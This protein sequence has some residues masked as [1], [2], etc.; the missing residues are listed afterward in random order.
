MASDGAIIVGAGPYGLSLASYLRKRNIGFQIFG[1]QM[2]SW[3]MHMPVG[4][5]LKSEAFASNLWD[6]D[7]EHTLE[8]FYNSSGR[9]YARKGTPLAV[10]DLLNYSDWF[11][12]RAVPEIADRMLVSL[13]RNGRDFELTFSDGHRIEAERVVLATGHM[14]FSYVPEVL[15]KLPANVAT[16]SSV[17]RDFA[18]FSGRDVTVVGAG[19]SALETAALL[20]EQGVHVRVIARAGEVL[21][22]LP[23]RKSSGVQS[24]MHVEAGLGPGW[25]AWA[26]SELPR[27]FSRLPLEKRR[28]IVKTAFGP[29]GGWW[30]KE[31]VLRKIPLLTAHHI[32]D[33]APQGGKVLLSVQHAG[34]VSQFETDH[35]IA[36]TGYKVDVDRLPFLDSRLR[37]EIRTTFGAPD[38]TRNF[39]SSV[40][41]LYFVGLPSAQ[42][43]GPVMRF[44]FGAKH[45][46]PIVARHIA[47]HSRTRSPTRPIAAGAARPHQSSAT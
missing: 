23:P 20:H 26:I 37:A 47:S 39:E 16:H 46:A 24:I 38:L 17:H 15:S 11:A 32:V 33:A 1:R 45:A 21:W 19:Q 8:Q 36:A 7:H 5:F 43:F 12:Q 31:R 41:G 2:N 28:R 14:A 29:A 30:L 22:N 3:R 4:M 9:P 25:R 13:A 6:P 42:T 40:P 34:V 27:V 18:Q 10:A 35:V 44:M